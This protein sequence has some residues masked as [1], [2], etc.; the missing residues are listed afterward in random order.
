MMQSMSRSRSAA[1]V[2]SYEGAIVA[3]G[4]HD[5]LSIFD[6]AEQFDPH[7]QT[8][9]PMPSMKS[10]RCRLGCAVLNYKLYVCGGYDGM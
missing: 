10:K 7:T 3:L 4:G 2:V 6:S 1:G 8:W 9:Q 5:G